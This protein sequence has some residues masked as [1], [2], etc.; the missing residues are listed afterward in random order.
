MSNRRSKTLTRVLIV[1]EKTI[2]RDGLLALIAARP[3]YEVVAAM[4]GINAALTSIS[5]SVPQ[6]VILDPGL[7]DEDGVSGITKIKRIDASIR[8]IVLTM[9]PSDDDIHLAL[10][11]GADAY[12]LKEDSRA[13]LFSALARVDDSECY[14]SP[15]VCER[16][17]GCFISSWDLHKKML[18]PEILT[19]REREV[20]RLIA[21]GRRTREIAEHFSVSPKTIDKHRTNLMKKLDLHN[22]SAVTVYAMQNGLVDEG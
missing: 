16:V 9:T 19:P 10:K 1:D 22:I 13:E 6:V 7:S 17:I 3:G 2:F 14:L 21:S 8:V 20:I 12:V 18:T 4:D 11:A 15:T 5:E